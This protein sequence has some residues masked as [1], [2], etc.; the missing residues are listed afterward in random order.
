MKDNYDFSKGKRNPYAKRLKKQV[1][2]RLDEGTLAYFK[3]L[4]EDTG[5]PYQTLI[6]LFLRDCAR[7]KKKPSMK[8]RATGS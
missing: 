5:I 3:D 2:I 4:A 6:N 8:W 1:T 7:A